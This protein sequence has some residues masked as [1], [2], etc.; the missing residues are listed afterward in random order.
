MFA[1]VCIGLPLVVTVRV[2]EGAENLAG[3][4]QAIAAEFVG[5]PND[6]T[7]GARN[8]ECECNDTTSVG[9]AAQAVQQRLKNLHTRGWS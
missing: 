7:C 9:R 4:M 6:R 1:V 5:S 8:N 3:T 2:V